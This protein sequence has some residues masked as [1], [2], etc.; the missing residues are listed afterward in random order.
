MQRRIAFIN[1]KG[2]CGKTTT[3]FHIAGELASRGKKVLVIDFDAQCDTSV[4][5]LSEEESEYDE[6]AGY[7]VIDLICG[8]PLENVA[9]KNYIKVG[10]A[11]PRYYGIDV[12]P[13]HEDLNDQLS[14]KE[15]VETSNLDCLKGEGYDYVFYD[16][17]PS[18]TVVQNTVLSVATGVLVPM[19]CSLGNVRGYSKIVDVVNKAR[20]D[21]PILNIDGVFL[22]M[23]VKRN[24][25]HNNYRKALL[26]YNT[27][28]DVQIPFN[29][30]VVRQIEEKGQPLA[31]RKSERLVPKKR[32]A[33]LVNAIFG[34]D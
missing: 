2:G 31:F 6:G 8:V 21:N 10:N 4:N 24:A 33:E 11:K 7:S 9:K 5:F 29:P 23:F 22:S 20:I 1:R 32:F 26:N 28:I 16:C 14:L 3:L 17:P 15:M 13:A 27:F 12:V 30:I 34:E 19:D 18:N 25:D